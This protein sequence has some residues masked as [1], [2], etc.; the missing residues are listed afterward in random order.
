MG[1]QF[2]EVLDYVEQQ[3]NAT[4]L[5]SD[6]PEYID[7]WEKHIGYRNRISTNDT[8]KPYKLVR[9]SDGSDAPQ[10][11]SGAHERISMFHYSQ[12][13]HLVGARARID[14]LTTLENDS[15]M[16]VLEKQLQLWL[17]FAYTYMH[18]D[19]ALELEYEMWDTLYQLNHSAPFGPSRGQR[20]IKM[21]DIL[22]SFKVWQHDSDADSVINSVGAIRHFIIHRIRF[23][24]EI[25]DEK[26]LF[27]VPCM[28]LR[29]TDLTPLWDDQI[30]DPTKFPKEKP[31]I[32]S[33]SD[34]D[35]VLAFLRKLRPELSAKL[36]DEIASA[37][38]QYASVKT[39]RPIPTNAKFSPQMP[40]TSIYPC[41]SGN[42]VVPSG[43]QLT[44]TGSISTGRG[45]P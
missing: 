27:C 45:I 9:I 15:K 22:H 33:R 32:R 42:Y 30:S 24:S 26:V 21:K 17:N 13:I 16:P 34:F 43:V 7:F 1:R 18:L 5:R 29:M 38:L 11:A 44:T 3:N 14:T 2:N 12:F 25:A 4:F 6:F 41:G 8:L 31:G 19:S 36:S 35:K 23:A 28:P 39:I 20:N 37:H 10:S 40:T